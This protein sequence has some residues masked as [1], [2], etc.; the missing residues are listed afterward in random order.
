MSSLRG[1]LL[2]VAAMAGFAVEDA[3]IKAASATVP[4]GQILGMLG[5]GGAAIFGTLAKSRGVRIVSRDL[6]LRPVLVRNGSE[7]LSTMA[8]VSA[9]AIAPLA[10]ISAIL[11]AT[12][13]AVT[14]GAALFLGEKVGWRRWLAIAVG[15]FGVLLIVQPGA[16]GFDPN[17]WIAVAAAIGLSLRDLATRPVPRSVPT[18]LLASYSFGAVAIAGLAMLP[19]GGGWITP[20]PGMALLIL[21][22]VLMGMVAYFSITAAMRVGEISVVTPMRYTRLVFAF[23]IALL[24]FDETLDSLT[25]VGVAIVVATGLYSLWRERQV[26]R[27]IT[28]P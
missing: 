28:A 6:F 1:I 17:I 13:L 5:L 22:G 21:A 19:F 3:L 20:T 9:I 12:P 4:V 24:V 11:Q 14:L 27:V 8:F 2:M 25:L 7:M 15:L 26:R 18:T 10:T 23:A 16:E